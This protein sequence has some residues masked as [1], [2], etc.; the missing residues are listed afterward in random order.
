[1]DKRTLKAL[2]GSIRKWEKIVNG[3]GVDLADKNCPL[4]SLFFRFPEGCSG[5]P[6]VERTGFNLCS[7]TP[8]DK[9]L[10]HHEIRHNGSEVLK[11]ECDTCRRIAERELK[12]LKSLLPKMEREKK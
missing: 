2:K 11:V 5:C 8:Y 10:V 12:F 7:L 3:T 9:W 4:C 1:M 6:V